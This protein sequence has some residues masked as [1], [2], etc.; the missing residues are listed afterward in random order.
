M[1]CPKTQQPKG[2]Y[3]LLWKMQQNNRERVLS[4][5]SQRGGDA[6][7]PAQRAC[8]P[9]TPH[10]AARG[11]A[12]RASAQGKNKKDE[13]KKKEQ[14]GTRAIRKHLKTEE[15]AGTDVEMQC[16]TYDIEKCETIRENTWEYETKTKW[17]SSGQCVKCESCG[18]GK[19]EK[20]KRSRPRPTRCVHFVTRRT[21]PPGRP[22]R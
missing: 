3:L 7:H 20:K 21:G 16:E 1:L 8:C 22:C 5:A 13:K 6:N 19:H 17:N 11:E 9:A 18:K 10:A 4:V 15:N 12:P 2:L 14:R